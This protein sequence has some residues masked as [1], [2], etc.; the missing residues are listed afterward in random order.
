MSRQGNRKG[1]YT[2]LKLAFG[3]WTLGLGAAIAA[4][5]KIERPAK[6]A[7]VV[8]AVNISVAMRSPVT[9]CS[10]SVDGQL[11]GSSLPQQDGRFQVTW[12]SPWASAGQ[13]LISVN[14]YDSTNTVVAFRSRTFQKRTRPSRTPTATATPSPRATASPTATKS[15]TPT[16]SSTPAPSPT[17]TASPTA[18]PTPTTGTTYYVA[19]TG[20]DSNSGL[21]RISPWKTIQHAANTLQ[22]G[23]S[24]IVTAGTYAERINLSRS[25]KSGAP[26]TLEADGSANVVTRGF[27]IRASF[28][29]VVGFE[30][31]TQANDSDGYGVYL[32]GTGMT[33]VTVR[34]N[35]IHDLC[36]E[37]IYFEPQVGNNILIQGN[38]IYR[39]AMAGI[40]VDGAGA[41]IDGNEI[42]GTQ[43]YP[44]LA[45]AITAFCAD[46]GG[47]DA[48]GIRFF[49]SNHV[50]KNNYLHDIQ[51][52]TAINPDP[53]IDCFQT[54]GAYSGPG[55]A[56]SN[57][58]IAGNRCV[59]P[60]TSDNT[61]NEI[62]S[63]EALNGSTVGAITYSYNVFSNMRNGVVIGSGVG[64]IK[65]D[66]NTVDH[67]LDEASL[68]FPAATS[69]ASGI[70]NNIFYDCGEASDSF[71]TGRGFTIGNNDCIM[72][73]GSDC[74]SYPADY[75]HVSINP[76]FVESGSGATPWL[77]ADYHLQPAS[78]AQSMG[79]CGTDAIVTC[80]PPE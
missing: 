72:R 30:I 69:S 12:N 74:G 13:H 26:L 42:W 38:L 71:A 2:A 50:I 66:H 79:A 51:F 24:A 36:R 43:E 53:H 29:Q 10:V 64:T 9:W 41:T 3:L 11:L 22:P 44:R 58:L 25:G 7:K 19:P 21:S 1:G 40:M 35:I 5:L 73:D 39:S 61:D 47:A 34:D 77:N 17:P 80:P 67:I 33:G 75:S 18:S 70:T 59:W 20:S 62:S 57:I 76:L 63:I 4:P 15:P 27:D 14:G 56:T 16:A 37:G 32:S 52:G 23:D 45:G 68:Q 78:A 49:G 48:D 65:F 46:Q 8:Q 6:G 60:S 31:T 28:V 54:W 55:G